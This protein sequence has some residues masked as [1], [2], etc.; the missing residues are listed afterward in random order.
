[1]SISLY[2]QKTDQFL[3]N[4]NMLHE[5]LS[6]SM[7]KKVKMMVAA[8]FMQQD[9]PFKAES[10]LACANKIKKESSFFSTMRSAFRYTIAGL[11][12]TKFD[13][14][15]AAF[16]KL[17]EQ[18]QTLYEVGFSKGNF[19][20]LAAY[21]LLIQE[22]E[23]EKSKKSV[24]KRAM[25]IYKEMKKRH[26]FLTSQDDY[27]LAVLVAS[28]EKSIPS[29][30]DEMEFYY[31]S[32]NKYG[33]SKGNELQ[34]LSHILTKGSTESAQAIVKET[35]DWF[36]V[37]QRK[38]IAL[39]RMHYPSLGLLALVSPQQ[40]NVGDVVALYE[41]LKK[42]KT[43]RFS[44]DMVLLIAIQIIISEKIK[45]NNILDIGLTTTI[46]AI[47][48]AQQVAMIAAVSSAAAASAASSSN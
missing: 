39:K 24:A 31:Q 19:L 29:L 23:T 22:E 42:E 27:P 36:N 35:V 8:Q 20:Y 48:Q 28:S 3:S 38:G 47:I 2:K 37:L 33:F 34:T 46:E 12:M 44:R 11:L 45:D 43:F 4:Y 6:F 26:F 7:D 16:K 30:L 15:D 25:E 1:M 41:A 14:P 40:E 17:K 32:L 10:F 18:Y 13:N 21:V 5:Q 9:I